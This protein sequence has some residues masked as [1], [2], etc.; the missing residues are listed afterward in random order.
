MPERLGREERRQLDVVRADAQQRRVLAHAAALH[1][2][3]H[4]DHRER[5]GD[6]IVDRGQENR[7]RAAA[8]L[9]GDAD[10]R[11]IHVGQARHEVQRAHAVPGLQAHVRL[12]PEHRVGVPEPLAVDERLAVGV[13]DHVVVKDDE[14]E[15]REVGGPRL[16]RIAGQPPACARRP[17]RRASGRSSRGARGTGRSPSGRAPQS[18]AGRFP[19]RPTGR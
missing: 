12:Q 1:R 9:A 14:A 19:C 17:G 7:L 16:Q 6:P 13:A 2:A 11:R 8:A 15:A 10:A 18:T 3:R 4:H 5:R